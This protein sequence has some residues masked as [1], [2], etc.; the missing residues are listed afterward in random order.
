MSVAGFTDV[1]LDI[2]GGLVTD[3]LPGDLPLGVSPDCQDVAFT[4]GAVRTRPGLVSVFSPI[5]GNPTVN[6]LKTYI[7]PAQLERMLALD[8][9]GVLWKEASAG[10]L[11]EIGSNLPSG[12]RAKSTTIF[13]REYIATSD[14][15]FGIGM[16]LQ[17]DDTN[18]DRVSQEGPGAGPSITEAA[19]EP[20]LTI[21]TAPT[22]AVRSN[23]VATITTTTAHGYQVGQTILIA[24]GVIDASFGGLFLVGS[25]PSATTFT[26][27][28]PGAT[29]TSGGDGTTTG[30][31]ATLQP[32]V[33]PGV[34]QVAV[35]FETRQGFLTA[36]SASVNWTTGGGRRAAI[37]N[38]PTGPS[39]VIARILAFTGANGA[40]F[41]YVGSN[42]PQSTAMR[43][44]DNS[45]TSWTV[46]FSDSAL[47]AGTNVDGLF[48]QAVLG[49]C[50][51][52]IDYSSRVFWWG[53]RN[54]VDNF[55]NLSFDGGFDTTST[56]PLGWSLDSTDGGGGAAET[57]V[58]NWGFAYRIGGP[59]ATGPTLRGMITQSAFQDSEGVPILAAATAYSIRVR[60]AK[61]S[62]LGPATLVMELFSATLGQLA[63]ATVSS[64]QLG[65]EYQEFIVP[66]SA[67]TP[68]VMPSDAVLRVYGDFQDQPG[69]AEFIYVDD[70]EIF[71]TAQP[72]NVSQ[73]RGS[74]VENPESF[75]ADTGVLSIAE[76]NGQAVRAAFRLREQLYFVKERSLYVTQDD[77]S[78][79]PDRWTI[80]EVSRSVGTP[81]V[82]GVD[83]GEDWAV[84]AG[85][86]GVYIFG[87]SE[88]VKI[89][90]E[91]QPTWDQIN[92][93]YGHT[94]WTRVDTRNKRILV[95]V[96]LGAAAT[97]PNVVLMMDYRGLASGDEI[98]SASPI[99]FSSITKK[100]FCFGNSRKW[101]PWQISANSAALVERPDGTAQLFLGNSIGNGKIYELSQSQL[102]DDG[103][104]INSYYTTAY[105]V[106]SEVEESLQLRSH[107]KLFGYLTSF[108]E[109]AGSISLSALSDNSTVVASLPAV[110]L[111]SP[112]PKDLE[113]PINISAER[114]A[115]QVGT[116]SP[117][118]WFS[119]QRIVPSMATDPWA[120]VRGGN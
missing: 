88:P 48:S 30:G 95:G 80:S 99:H 78:N 115:F 7:T 40:S 68:A 50:A 37:S 81:S 44:A 74:G 45:T 82:N 79:E 86:D 116:N 29:M 92:W 106:P 4:A 15:K 12:A 111:S 101:S 67:A 56:T 60:T 84:I 55:V 107:R 93:L 112:S 90:Q 38:I 120:V 119:L 89:S 54:R 98:A 108:V 97:S 102:S 3:M 21:A 103:I 72:F 20:T 83:V 25:A 24:G 22:G 91:I 23:N 35:I 70:I 26:Y 32:Q 43:I 87:G 1:A 96:P 41:F 46:D 28:N 39:N 5:P 33:S 62:S 6:Y 18:L 85:R 53:E 100:L 16:P 9:S 52:A 66:F 64:S 110:A 11:S 63:V 73:V 10:L 118:S 77:G 104:G 75:D 117:G 114:V 71:P 69:L 94:I 57:S 76:S 49:E 27:A 65:A 36:P 31:S 113:M 19:V 2:F 17:Y 42:V 59:A 109:G 47:L 61:G 51:G 8:S 34:H 58:V 14:G 105:F 13:G